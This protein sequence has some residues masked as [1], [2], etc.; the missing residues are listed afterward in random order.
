MAADAAAM[1]ARDEE[2]TE[3]TENTHRGGTEH[4]GYTEGLQGRR[5]ALRPQTGPADRG[6]VDQMN[7]V[8]RVP[9]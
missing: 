3:I 9:P 5:A 6:V 7:C 2:I 4:T 8:F 1:L